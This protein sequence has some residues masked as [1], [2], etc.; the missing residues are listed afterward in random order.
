MPPSCSVAFSDQIHVG[1]HRLVNLIEQFVQPDEM[2]A[3][4][5]PVGLFHLRLQIHGV[6]Q[7]LIQ[8]GVQFDAWR[9]FGAMSFS[10][11]Y[12]LGGSVVFPFSFFIFLVFSSAIIPNNLSGA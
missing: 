8:Q 3:F 2:R 9:G 11:S 4:D 6:G 5:I 1:F 10:V 7:A 12:I